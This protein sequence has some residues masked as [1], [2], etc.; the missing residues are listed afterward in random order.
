MKRNKF[1]EKNN[2]SYKVNIILASYDENDRD[3]IGG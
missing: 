2:L 1:I 3:I